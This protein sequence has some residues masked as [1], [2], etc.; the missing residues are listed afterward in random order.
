ML[1]SSLSQ[2][3]EKGLAHQVWEWEWGRVAGEGSAEGFENETE[4]SRWREEP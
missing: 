3:K 2:E 4:D 1:R